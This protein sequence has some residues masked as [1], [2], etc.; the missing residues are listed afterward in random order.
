MINRL[1][2][3]LFPSEIKGGNGGDLGTPFIMHLSGNNKELVNKINTKDLI[4]GASLCSHFSFSEEKSSSRLLVQSIMPKAFLVSV[5]S[6]CMHGQCH[7]T[8]G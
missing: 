1:L 4:Y 3:S 7:S 5:N 8:Q 6:S 2:V